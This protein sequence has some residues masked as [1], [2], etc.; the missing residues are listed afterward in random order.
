[1]RDEDHGARSVRDRRKGCTTPRQRQR[2]DLASSWLEGMLR[3]GACGQVFLATN[4]W[5]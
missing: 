5:V 2:D 4:G 3:D 1:V